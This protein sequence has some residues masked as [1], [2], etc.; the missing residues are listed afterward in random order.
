VLQQDPAA[1]LFAGIPVGI[2]EFMRTEK[3]LKERRASKEQP[4]QQQQPQQ[5]QQPQQQ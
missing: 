4:Q 1:E 5:P 3:M 2:R